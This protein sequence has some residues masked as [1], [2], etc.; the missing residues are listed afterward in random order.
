MT[1]PSP[2]EA[3]ALF[4]KGI[5]QFNRGEFFQSHESW[6]LIWLPAPE[7]DKTFLQAIIQV[8]AALHHYGRRNLA[9]ARSLLARGLR[10]IETFPPDYRTVD[11]EGLRASARKW[12]HFLRNATGTPPPLPAIRWTRL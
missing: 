1:S 12:Q 9:G 4:E 3:A 6:E 11:V 10:K 5:A 7:P 8:A 2:S